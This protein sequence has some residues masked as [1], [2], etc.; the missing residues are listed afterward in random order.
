MGV[1]DMLR[2][3]DV[4]L[5][6]AK[7]SRTRV[8]V[9]HPALD[10]ANRV[11]LETIRDLDEAISAP[12]FVLHY[13]PKID[14][15]TGA[16]FGAEAL[17]RWQHPTRGLLYPDAF[18]PVVEQCGLMNAVTRLVL[19]TA[20]AQLAQWR[21]DG[22]DLSIAVNLSASDLLDESLAERISGLLSEHGVP[23]D[24]LELE[25]T[26]SVIMT[27]P[28][29]A[30]EV[31]QSLRR[32]GLL[33]AVDDYGTGYCALSYLRDL[34]VD[35]LKIDRTFIDR[36]TT[37]PRTEAIVH[38]TIELAHALDIKVVAEGVEHEEALEALVRLDCDYAQGYHFS[39]PLPA[40][41]FVASVLVRTLEMPPLSAR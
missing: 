2:Q 12:Q 1:I 21:G 4:S 26:E 19:E 10:A 25:I 17:V 33:I 38:S 5:Y 7:D 20:V 13:Q 23:A 40:E 24:A 35:E 34:P 22:L 30:R 36:L 29:R 14:V 11:R 8:E 16:T 15:A 32:L 3:A 9:Y 39:R 31:L 41:A 27:D 18:L 6:A 37:D 28:G